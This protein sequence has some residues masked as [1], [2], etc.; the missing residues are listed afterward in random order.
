MTVNEFI[1]VITQRGAQTTAP[2]TEQ[3]ITLLNATLRQ[4]R[5]AMLPRAMI[6]LYAITGS[7]N[8]D[9]G[10]IFGPI[11]IMR[12]GVFPIPDILTINNDIAPLGK[13]S[14]MTIFGR[15]DL[16]WFAFNAFGQFFMLDN[17]T[18]KPLRKYDDPYRAMIDC[19]IAGKF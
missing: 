17:L 2:A 14:G 8:L 11:E 9:T 3:Q 12:N 4:N 18:L 13:T 7:L 15:N 10:Y 5:F 1:S 19:L 16:F 6:D